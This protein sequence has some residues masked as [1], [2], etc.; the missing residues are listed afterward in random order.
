MPATSHREP[1]RTVRRGRWV[2]KNMVVDQRKLDEARRALGTATE[3]DTVDRAL[4]LVSFRRELTRGIA[5]LRKRGG[6]VDVLE[7][8]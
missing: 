7:E 8:R 2:R 6:F 5:A 4:D 3:T 1:K